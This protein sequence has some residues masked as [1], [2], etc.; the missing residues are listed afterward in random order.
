MTKGATTIWERWDILRPD[1]TLNPGGTTSF[2]HYA[3]GAVA[4]WLHRVVG[5]V[6]ATGYGKNAFRPRPGGEM[7]W[8]RTRHETPYGTVSLSWEQT[9]TGL[10][11]DIVVPRA[12]MRPR[13]CP[14]AHRS[15]GGRAL[16]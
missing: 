2:K 11:A 16:T 15:R 13:S 12:A 4:D 3:L 10:T 9:A 1:D 14:A 7:T 6:T 5:G 8:A